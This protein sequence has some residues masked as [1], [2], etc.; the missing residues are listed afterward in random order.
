MVQSPTTK[1]SPWHPFGLI[2]ALTFLPKTAFTFAVVAK[3]AFAFAFAFAFSLRWALRRPMPLLTT[4]ETLTIVD[5]IYLSFQTFYLFFLWLDPFT[6]VSLIT[7]A[8][9]SF[10]G[11]PNLALPGPGQW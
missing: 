9:V 10:L 8:P 7:L 5:C 3:L 2:L 6:T 4:F 1:A 11:P